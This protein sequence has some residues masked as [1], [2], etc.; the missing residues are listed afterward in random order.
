MAISDMIIV[1]LS[2][3]GVRHA[4]QDAGC[5]ATESTISVCEIMAQ[6]TLPKTQGEIDDCRVR[7]EKCLS[8]LRS[9]VKD[10]GS[11]E[12]DV[13]ALLGIDPDALSAAIANATALGLIN[14]LSKSSSTTA[15]A[16]SERG[17]D[18]TVSSEVTQL[19]MR[20]NDILMRLSRLQVD[21]KRL[22][23]RISHLMQHAKASHFMY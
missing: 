14:Q 23:N 16:A 7:R 18:T 2:Q 17:D 6:R 4:I 10:A 21:Q 5:P 11:D 15:T 13:R 22:R 19:V 12:S 8:E 3:D 9:L 20:S 1:C